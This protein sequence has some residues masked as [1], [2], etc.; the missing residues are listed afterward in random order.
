MRL[1][2]LMVALGHASSRQGAKRLIKMGSVRVDGKK[3]T[4]P[5]LDVDF[6]S[7]ICVLNEDRPAGYWKLKMLDEK[8]GLIHSGDRVLDVG[9]SSGGFL[10]YACEKAGFVTGI[11]F[12]KE[13]EE[14]LRKIEDKFEN[15]R[16][17]F[18]DAF[19]V[20]PETLG[21]MDVILIDVTTEVD[22][23]L[24]LL[25]KYT[26]ILKKQGKVLVVFKGVDEMDPTSSDFGDLKILGI[27]KSPRKEVYVV[28]KKI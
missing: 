20:P 2:E 7:E 5:S 8:Y 27:E 17:L 21:I 15:V 3:V 25:R 9:S 18:G 22:G 4:K 19:R 23:S 13:F 10:L 6:S 24:K 28:L 16:V 26:R 1:D 14:K 12:S 11:E